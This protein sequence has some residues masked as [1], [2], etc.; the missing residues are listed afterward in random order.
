MLHQSPLSPPRAG[1]ILQLLQRT[2][3]EPVVLTGD[4]PRKWVVVCPKLVGRVMCMSFAGADGQTRACSNPSQMQQGFCYS[5][6][7]AG[8]GHWNNFGGIERIWFTPEG[9]LFGFS[10]PPGQP[11]NLDNY[12]IP[13]AM[14]E[15]QYGITGRS[16]D[17]KS[18]TFTAPIA[19]T[20]YRGH[21]VRLSVR[22]QITVLDDCPFVVGLGPSVRYVGFESNTWATNAGGERLNRDATPLGLW[23]LGIYN[24]G[25]HTVVLLPYRQGPEVQLG[26]PV[27][28]EYLRCFLPHGRMPAG[29]WATRD[30]CVIVKADGRVQ[31][32]LEMLRRRALGRLA[33]LDLDALS[34]DIV[35]FPIYP[36]RPYPASYFLPYRGDP[37]DGGVLSSYMNEGEPGHADKPA[38]HELEVCSPLLELAPGEQFCHTSRV[39]QVQGDEAAIDQICRRHFSTSLQQLKAFAGSS[40]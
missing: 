20:N 17:G 33:S 15:Q 22:R 13:P 28:T 23:T 27:S 18:V 36:E 39:Y 9:G 21:E 40:S 25:P 6:C 37:L 24:S 2:A 5:G 16:A 10:F 31:S 14:Q 32:K 12:V 34:I 19:M 1:E 26:P 11:Q 30:G 35:D 29:Q 38:I 4:D 3:A 7:G 8:Q